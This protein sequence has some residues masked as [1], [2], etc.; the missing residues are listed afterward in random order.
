MCQKKAEHSSSVPSS[1]TDS[2]VSGF[3]SWFISITTN[4]SQ[5]AKVGKV[6]EMNWPNLLI[7]EKG[8][9]RFYFFSLQ[10]KQHTKKQKSKEMK[11]KRVLIL[12]D[13]L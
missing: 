3:S 5:T 4:F 9:Y 7:Q 8:G 2:P 11:T 6:E 12:T 10:T 1:R 13:L